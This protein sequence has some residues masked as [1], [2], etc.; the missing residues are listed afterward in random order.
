M[1]ARRFAVCD[2]E[3][4]PFKFLR[5]PVPFAW[6]YYNGLEYRQFF[7]TKEFADFIATRDEVIYAHNGGRFDFHFLLDQLNDFQ[8][9][10]I[11]NGRLA[12]AK[13]GKATLRDSLLILPIPL[14]AFKKDEIDYGKFEKERRQ[15][16]MP[17]ILRYLEMD[18]RYLYELIEDFRTK[19]GNRLTLAGAAMHFWAENFNAGVKPQTS[20]AYYKSIFPWYAGGMVR[21]FKP[22]IHAPKGGIRSF[23][24]NS[25]YPYAMTFEHPCGPIAIQKRTFTDKA[26]TRSFVQIVAPSVGYFGLMQDGKRE[27]PSDGRERV[28]HVTGWELKAALEMGMKLTRV[29]KTMEFVNTMKFDDYVKHFFK[30]K[31]EAPK[32]SSARLL[33]KLAL[34][35]LY[36]KFAANPE[37]YSR[38]A[39][40]PATNWEKYASAKGFLFLDVMGEK[41]LLHA[42]LPQSQERYYDLAEGASVT[43]FVR[44]VLMKAIAQNDTYYCDTD[45][46]HI[47]GEF[48]GKT[49]TGLGDWAPEFTAKRAAYAGPKL[50]AME[51]DNGKMKTASKGVRLSSA[52]IFRLA[53][54]ETVTH[55]KDAPTFSIR[56]GASFTQRNIVATALKAG[57]YR[58]DNLVV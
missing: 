57:N 39:I 40:A 55:K 31:N 35:S 43:G 26:L 32:E 46:V 23:D 6:A 48:R 44:A 9:I 13:L 2:C 28:F 4:D 30:L 29:I 27:Y 33:A 18:C 19:F 22:G 38:F 14:K 50:Y 21:V 12:Q 45:C 36:G 7:D 53:K 1:K 51:G 34:N 58:A 20:K 3:T 42:P 10:K 49:G 5:V 52:D 16:N 54:G 56:R 24:I 47:A 37:N 41:V 11:I 8:E 15:D 25:A 17:E